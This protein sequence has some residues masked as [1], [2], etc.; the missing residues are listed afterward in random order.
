MSKLK[1]NVGLLAL[2][3]GLSISTQS[4][5]WG[6]IVFDP[7]N[8]G[9]NTVTATQ[10]VKQTAHQA[11]ILAEEVKQYQK[12]VQDLKQLNPAI[13]Q[14]G[15]SRG[16][17]PNGNYQT[18][19]EVANAAAG[20]Y[21]TYNSIGE[22]MKGYETTYG[23]IDT[24]MKDLDRTSISARVPQEKVLQYDFQRAQA[25][26]QQDSNYYT[27]LKNLTGQIGQHQKRSDALAAALPA[28][29]GTVELLQTLGSQNTVVQDQMTHLIQISTIN[30]AE[31]VQA[32]K[33]NKLKAEIEA[34]KRA[35]G[36]NTE[37]NAGNYFRN[38]TK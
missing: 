27:T 34:K 2:S 13:I 3:L 33:D 14:Q 16:Y 7:S 19:A 23:G 18:P 36:I 26:I 38:K 25:G 9:K 20:V 1:F 22:N 28:Q 24:L 32:S 35:A 12:M 11:A 21:G 30:A 4:M 8:F 10:Q 17:I 15:V 37:K 29:S 31:S 5:A 6:K